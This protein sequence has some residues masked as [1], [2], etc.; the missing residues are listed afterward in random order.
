ME[1]QSYAGEMQREMIREIELTKPKYLISVEISASWLRRRESE[2]LILDWANQYI[3][4]Y[5]E[6]VGL[7]NIV[8][9][10]RS[11]YY[12]GELPKPMPQCDNCVL[13]YQRKA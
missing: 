7:V 3:E 2:S 11:D 12:F 13:I 1:P 8:T 4:S 9:P 5:Y 6:A 10:E